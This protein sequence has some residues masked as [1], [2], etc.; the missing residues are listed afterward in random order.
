MRARNTRGR[1]QEAGVLVTLSRYE[2]KLRGFFWR[3]GVIDRSRGQPG[4]MGREL[5]A[6]LPA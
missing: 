2:G 6:G 3:A 5:R 4:E 1:L